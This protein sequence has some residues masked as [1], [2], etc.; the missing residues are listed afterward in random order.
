MADMEL[1]AQDGFAGDSEALTPEQ[2]SQLLGTTAFCGGLRHTKVGI[3][4]YMYLIVAAL[5]K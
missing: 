3:Y 4:Q 1:Q 2:L 5:S